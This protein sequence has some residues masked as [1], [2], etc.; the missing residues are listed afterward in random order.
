MYRRNRYSA[1]N[2]GEDTWQLPSPAINLTWDL[3]VDEITRKVFPVEDVLT[4]Y[5][6]NNGPAYSG[7]RTSS[8]AD[9]AHNWVSK[10]MERIQRCAMNIILYPNTPNIE[11][12]GECF[13]IGSVRMYDVHIARLCIR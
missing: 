10:V 1:S 8:M 4:V 11:A 6:Y 3:H 2:R 5:N 9:L 7:V 13:D 12:F